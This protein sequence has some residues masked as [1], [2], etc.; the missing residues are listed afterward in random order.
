MNSRTIDNPVVTETLASC[1][2]WDMTLPWIPV[3][4]DME[5]LARYKRAGYTF[6]SLTLQDWPPTFDGMQLCIERFKKMAQPASDW[7]VF[8]SSLAEI[9]RGRREGKLVLGLNSQETRPIEEDLSRIEALHALGVR[10]M[11]LAYNVRNLVADGCAEV[12]DAGLSNFGRQVVR[13]MNR[14]GMI[15]DCTH[16]GRRSSLEAIELCERPPIFSHSNA[17]SV[18]AHIRNIR[19]EQIRAC[20][21]RGGVIGVVGVG[22][23][24][25][26]VEARSESLFRHID[27]I[28]SL[29]G[30]QHVGLGTDYVDIFPIKEHAPRWEEHTHGNDKTWPDPAN[31]WPDPT[32]TQI[33]L[34]DSRCFRPEQLAELVEIMIDHGYP[35]DA[36]RGILG[37]NFRRVYATANQ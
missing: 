30:P 24:L 3:Y 10:H 4:W 32:G 13:E 27:Y 19:D 28:A 33:P 17:Y 2:V 35:T 7:L 20:A 36:I 8:G 15:L 25:G 34:G 31:G 23:F 12:A 5:I 37:S 9:D 18:C 6:V 14:V 22:A 16:T 1:D 26:D 11:L 29:V 21:A